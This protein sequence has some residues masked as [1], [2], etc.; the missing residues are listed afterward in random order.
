MINF[1][2]FPVVL[3]LKDVTTSLQINELVCVYEPTLPPVT[4]IEISL[5]AYIINGPYADLWK[6]VFA[7]LWAFSL[8]TQRI[9]IMPN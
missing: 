9:I 5:Q 2:S 7:N 3:S 1:K 6:T 8:F 4:V